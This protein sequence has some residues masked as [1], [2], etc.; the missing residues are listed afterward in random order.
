[1]NKI[2]SKKQ[3]FLNL[4]VIALF[5]ALIIGCAD[6]PT[7]SRS[8][9]VMVNGKVVGDNAPTYGIQNAEISTAQ[10]Q[11]DGSLEVINQN[12]AV[13]NTSGE[14]STQIQSGR[15][16]IVLIA[17]KGSNQWQA[18]VR[19][20]PKT[21]N[22]AIET[23]V[24]FESTAE[25]AVYRQIVKSGNQKDVSLSMVQQ[26]I[27]PNE[28]RAIRDH[29]S[30]IEHF[31]EM[32]IHHA[33]QVNGTS[34]KA[35]VGDSTSYV[36]IKNNFLVNS[37]NDSTFIDSIIA[38]FQLDAATVDSLLEIRQDDD[39]VSGEWDDEGE[40]SHETGDYDED[41][42]ENDF[43]TLKIVV[44]RD[45]YMDAPDSGQVAVRVRYAFATDSTARADLVAAIVLKTQL[46]RSQVENAMNFGDN[47][48][49]DHWG[50]DGEDN[51]DGHLNVHIQSTIS[52]SQATR[53]LIDSL[54]T[55]FEGD[56]MLA[57]GSEVRLTVEKQNGEVSVSQNLNVELPDDQMNLWNAVLNAVRGEVTSSS[58]ADISVEI[59]WE[60]DD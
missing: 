49:G 55:A 50:D 60:F 20:S 30:E 13:T 14:F 9:Q 51:E 39:S 42:H 25:A 17:K 40:D 43:S 24:N 46:T 32:I 54:T 52:L 18:L 45:G 59:Q 31:A 58:E 8:G 29:H 15:Q 56:M 41:H 16:P 27:G 7:S 12:Q 11:S 5:A 48:H 36:K 57:H 23:I 22:P 35:F 44:R 4:G 26:Y 10:I 47:D 53:D 2:Y 38:G 19:T 3:L 33:H 34:I 21:A 6:T 28:A 37:T 1:M